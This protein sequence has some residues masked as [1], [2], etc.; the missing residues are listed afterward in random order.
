VLLNTATPPH[1]SAPSKPRLNLRAYGT[2]YARLRELGGVKRLSFA[3]L[4]ASALVGGLVD[5][6][7]IF[8]VMRIALAMAGDEKTLPFDLGPL[9]VQL[10]LGS[11]L[12]LCGALLL[13][14][15]AA[16]CV[17]AR[18]AARLST[19]AIEQSRTLAMSAFLSTRW[20]V[21]SRERPSRLQ[22]L[23]SANV[24]RLG[25]SAIFVANGVVA[26]VNF[27]AFLLSAILI[28]PLAALVM[29]AGLVV[30]GVGVVPLTRLTRQRAA[31]QAALNT[32][33]SGSVSQ[34]VS[35]AREARVFNVGDAIRADMAEMSGRSARA[36]YST[37]FLARITPV[38]YQLV[39]LSL[40]IGGLAAANALAYRDVSSLGAM[41]VLL[42]RAISYG[43]QINTAVQQSSEMAP[44]I[45]DLDEQIKLY[46]RNALPEGGR[47]TPTVERLECTDLVL[48][49]EPGR[50]V[51][52]GLSF[53]VRRGE[54]IGIVGPSGGGKSTLLQV[55][56]R[57]REPQGGALL[58]N[59]V[60]AKEFSVASWY[61]QVALVPQDNHLLPGSVAEN[62]RFYRRELA[63][64]EIVQAAKLA[65]LHEEI[66]ALPSGYESQIGPGAMDLSGG[67]KQRLGL[68]RAL[69]GKPSILVL[70]EPTS[71][72]DMRSEALIQTT[73]A[74]LKGCITCF[75][76]AHRL[77]TL[78]SCDRVMVLE[79][80]QISAF[81]SSSEI[82]GVNRFFREA[83]D[84][85]RS[86]LQ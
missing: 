34:V 23:L 19:T 21:Q 68:A 47:E 69:A 30:F 14:S 72:L 33:Y 83:V 24:G 82:Q 51:L 9:A 35:L 5:A 77:S 13:V 49:Y 37:R 70:D 66:L 1:P 22:E 15:F 53:S 76:V 7:L 32:E 86:G 16:A 10:R 81:G 52:K 26:A 8:L 65:H 36:N 38:T 75:I 17:T 61:R 85:S 84:L 25:Q 31:E 50:P 11:A 74:G 58:A 44:Y 48:A 59:G 80:G 79:Q 71:A 63:E 29:G 62:I 6:S 56:L 60:D 41:V 20:E 12:G 45:S 64:S 57:L 55:I 2:V 42:V 78:S 40:V 28:T 46:R 67:Q 39:A 27:A 43:Q 18:T 4:A 3:I 73:L 54:T